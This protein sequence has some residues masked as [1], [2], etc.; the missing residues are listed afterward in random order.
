MWRE[1][2]ELTGLVDGWTE[3]LLDTY[4]ALPTG[5]CSGSGA[6]GSGGRDRRWWLNAL[7]HLAMLRDQ[8]KLL[9]VVASDPRAW[10]V[11][12]RVDAAHLAGLRE[13][14]SAARER[15][16]AAGAGPDLT[17]GLI[18]DHATITLSHGEKQNAAATWKQ[19]FR[20]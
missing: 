19:T 2:T 18:V 17:A 12:D 6:G 10:R 4:K 15:A 5:G 7:S 3:Q 13:V 20:P 14:R 9:A 11:I 16:W 1:L 8:D